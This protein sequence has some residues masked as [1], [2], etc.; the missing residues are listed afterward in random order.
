MSDGSTLMIENGSNDLVRRR[1]RNLKF[2]THEEYPELV[3]VV[4]T[5]R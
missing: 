5:L 3:D 4:E 1:E 2:K